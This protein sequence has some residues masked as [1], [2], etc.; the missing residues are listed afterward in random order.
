MPSELQGFT[1]QYTISD[2]N[3]TIELYHVD[4]PNHSDNMLIM[5]TKIDR[6]FA[7]TATA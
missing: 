2:G 3:E 7:R 5:A 1:D 6:I 4:G